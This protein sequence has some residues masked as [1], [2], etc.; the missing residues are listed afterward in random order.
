MLERSLIFAAVAICTIP[1][2]LPVQAQDSD[3]SPV[4]GVWSATN[5]AYTGPDTSWTNVSP[6]P[7]VLIFNNRH[8][9][10][11]RI[12]GSEPRELL[13]ENPT[14]DQ[15]L[16]AFRRVRMSAGWY[17]VDGAEMT[18][19]IV[20]HW[21]PNTQAQRPKYTSGFEVDGDQMVRTFTN[22]ARD[23]KWVVT[24]ERR[25]EAPAT[26]IDGTWRI[27]EAH[28]SSPDTSWAHGVDAPGFLSFHGGYYAV[29]RVSG[30]EPRDLWPEG[31]PTDEQRLASARRVRGSAGTFTV[32]NGELTLTPIVHRN[33]N[34]M[35]EPEP[36]TAPYTIDGDVMWRTFK[37]EENGRE[38]R[39]KYE[40]VGS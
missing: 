28:F 12:N 3:G 14:D 5:V 7:E 8:W 29:S 16:A 1:Y 18:T 21:N 23:R 22:T 32:S 40:R 20:S 13:P 19:R 34:R 24:Y 9:T 11:A 39:W 10:S 33:P 4:A 36:F 38:F 25:K 31:G 30:P 27:R 26:E 15:R 6:Q 2:A 17:T 35:A 37:N